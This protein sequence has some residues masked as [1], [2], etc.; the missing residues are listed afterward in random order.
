MNANEQDLESLALR[1]G[2]GDRAAGAALREQLELWLRRAVEEG[3][4][5]KKRSGKVLRYAARLEPT[6][7]DQAPTQAEPDA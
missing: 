2:R 7:F 3:H 4:V 6:L 5:R 1:A